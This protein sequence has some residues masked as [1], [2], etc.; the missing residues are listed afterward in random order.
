LLLQ[1]KQP[2]NYGIYNFGHKNPAA[3]KSS[4]DFSFLAMR[5][6]CILLYFH[7]ISLPRVCLCREISLQEKK[8]KEK[9]RKEKKRKEK[10]RKEKKRKEKGSNRIG[11]RGLSHCNKRKAI[12]FLCPCMEIFR[13]IVQHSKIFRKISMQA[14]LLF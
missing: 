7:S 1:T 10:K 9:K 4:D 8:R 2:K 5:S 6:P 14:Q 12:G 3:W 11:C 13:K